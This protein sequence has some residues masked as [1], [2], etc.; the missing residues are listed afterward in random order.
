M[1]FTLSL[2]AGGV[3]KIST[4]TVEI[5][6]KQVLT[7]FFNFLV[8]FKKYTIASLKL[9]NWRFLGGSNFVTIQSS[10]PYPW[11]FEV[12]PDLD[13]DPRIHASD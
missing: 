5:R 1:A 8:L 2:I 9:L 10:V 12:D 13:P 4:G 6:T 11:N 7:T 3:T